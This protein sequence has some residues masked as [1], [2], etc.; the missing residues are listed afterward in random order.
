LRLGLNLNT[1]K[2]YARLRF[3]TEPISP[4]GLDIGEGIT[5]VG[6]LPLPTGNVLP[7]IRSVPL[8]VEYRLRVNAPRGHARG[9][10]P[11]QQGPLDGG[12]RVESGTGFFARVFGTGGGG[13]SPSSGSDGGVELP[14]GARTTWGTGTG[15]G[16]AHDRN[17]EDRAYNPSRYDDCVSLSTGIDA[18]E[19]SVDELN[20]CLEWDEHSP[21]WDI[22]TCYCCYSNHLY[23]PPAL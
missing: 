16:D 13:H 1:Y 14:A 19:I 22:G 11:G 5:C 15:A 10:V 7:L 21:L 4:F 3:R 8:R 23:L 20:F 6:K 18:I 12:S 2:A 9:R 17:S